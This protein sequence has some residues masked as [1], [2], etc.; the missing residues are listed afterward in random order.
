MIIKKYNRLDYCQYLLSSQINYTITNM[1]NH[2]KNLSHDRINRYLRGEKLK[3]NILWE[4]VKKIIE[5]DND[6]IIIFDDTVLNKKHSYQIELVRR[7]YS[8]NEKK[9]IKGLG[10]V[11]CI[12]VNRKTEEFWIIDYRIYDPDGDGLS[13]LDHVENMLNNLVYHKNMP[14]KTV[15]MDSWY[16][17]KRIILLIEKL[18]K[19]YYCPLKKNRLVDD[20]QGLKPYQKLIHGKI[21]KLNKFPA[22]HKVKLFRVPVSTNRTDYVITNNINQSSTDAVLIECGIRWKIEEFHREIKQLTGIESC[23]SFLGFKS[24]GLRVTAFRGQCRQ[25]RIQRNHI[26]CAMFVWLRLKQ[27]AFLVLLAFWGNPRSRSIRYST[28]QNVYQLKHQLLSK[29]LIRELKYP[30]I[31]MSFA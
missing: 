2:I 1:A 16:A 7:Q 24:R 8:G 12:Y 30:S 22:T 3:P 17:T 4:T 18:E 15:L 11:N 31:S 13:K 6:G 10:V 20:S 28:G 21:I 14:F 25:A 19:I 9:V 23:H 5:L 27:I 26:N 29:Y